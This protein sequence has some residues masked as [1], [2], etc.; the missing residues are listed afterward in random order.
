[1]MFLLLL[2]CAAPP[3]D[4][5]CIAAWEAA[6]NACPDTIEQLPSVYCDD[7]PTTCSLLWSDT[8]YGP[9]DAE[10]VQACTRASFHWRL[11]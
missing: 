9:V 1:M 3:E 8:G 4:D 5:A 2:A 6:C 7:L 10:A 11:I